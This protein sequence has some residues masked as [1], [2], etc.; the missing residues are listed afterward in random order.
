MNKKISDKQLWIE[1]QENGKTLKQIADEYGYKDIGNLSN[2][3]SKVKDY[4]YTDKIKLSKVGDSNTRHL[5]IQ[6][7][8][9]EEAGLDP[10]VNLI[11]KRKVKPGEIILKLERDTK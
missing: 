4:R 6:A 3:L 7:R 8:M 2:R 1:Y 9:I 11:A 5:S 10:E